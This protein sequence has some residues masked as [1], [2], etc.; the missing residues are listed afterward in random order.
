MAQNTPEP[1]ENKMGVMPVDKLILNISLPM[2]VSML[3]QA[4]YNVVDSIFVARVSENA[5]SALSLAFPMQSLMIAVSTGTGVGINALVSRALGEKNGRRAQ[6]VARNG[7]FLAA[8]SF[9]LFLLIGIFAVPA[10]FRAQTDVEEILTYGD[11][12]LRICCCVSFGLFGSI[13]FERLLQSTGRTVYTMIAQSSG[14]VI[15]IILD[16]ILIFGLFGLPAMGVAGAALATVIGQIGNMLIALH[17]CRHK[18]PEVP[19]HFQGFRPKGEIIASIYQIGIPSI[20]MQAISSVMVFGVNKI[21]IAFSTT[22]TAVFGVYFK[23]QSFV[24]MPVFGLN[25][26]LVPIIGYNYGARKAERIRQT[27]RYGVLYAVCIMAVGVLLFQLAPEL[28]LRLFDASDEMLSIGRVALRVI[29]ISFLP[30]A[31]AIVCGSVFQALGSAFLSMIVSIAR[32]LVVLLP[33][34]WLLSLSGQLAL[35]WWAF[36]IAEIISF[37][38]SALFFRWIYHKRIQ[39]LS[40][41]ET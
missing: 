6:D 20:I 10:F 38:L 36:P 11:Q 18:N 7:V 32:Q 14:A 29:S 25:N 3:V 37:V 13:T 15:N 23:L 9:V 26:G 35:V 34:A 30:A 40:Q 1:K 16:P 22:A 39:P 12:Y 24:F 21:L 2:M 28:L 27:F 17:F 4:L 8:C 5:L 33:A 31:F 41:P 19:L